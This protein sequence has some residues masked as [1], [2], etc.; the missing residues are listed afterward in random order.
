MTTKIPSEFTF[1]IP[2]YAKTISV[3]AKELNKF[4]L[5]G[6]WNIIFHAVDSVLGR[7]PLIVV[8]SPHTTPDP[9]K[10]IYTLR[11]PKI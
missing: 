5:R 10:F 11:Q 9:D 3:T 4:D 2:G 7:K 1:F 8:C 6:S